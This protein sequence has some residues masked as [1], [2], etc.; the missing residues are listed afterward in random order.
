MDILFYKDF[1]LSFILKTDIK[2]EY[3]TQIR[4]I[5]DNDNSVFLYSKKFIEF[6]KTAIDEN[7]PS[8]NAYMAF[9]LKL[10]QGGKLVKSSVNST[11]F[12]DE[13][14]HIY[15]SHSS[16]TI[17][18]LSF[19]ENVKI[20]DVITSKIGILSQQQKPNYHW[21]VVQLAICHPF[22]LSVDEDD[23]NE[24]EEIDKFFA[25][26]FSIPKK[27]TEVTIFDDYYNLES[28]NKYDYIRNRNNISN[29]KKIIKNI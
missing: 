6:L 14:I 9:V 12:E 18:T 3:K 29:R 1:I 16:N 28:H 22:T 2:V 27:I 10:Q 5:L 4:K 23:F 8:F 7:S 25:D 17:I 19:S 13:F 15:L 21:L 20:N 24:N 11:S 26:L